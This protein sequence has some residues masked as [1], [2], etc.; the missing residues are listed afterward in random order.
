MS[1]LG[2]RL[3]QAREGQGLSLAQASV[4]TRILQQS[5]IAL[6]EGAYQR[7]PGDVVIRGFIR[8]YAQYLA[9]PADELIELYRRERGATDKIRIVPATNPPRSRSYV[10]PSFFGVFFVTVALIGLAYV[11]L[12]AIGRIGDGGIASVVTV[13][14]S[15]TVPPP[16]PLPSPTAGRATAIAAAPISPATTPAPGTPTAGPAGG[17]SFTATQTATASAPIIVELRIAAL[18]GDESS[19]VRVQSDGNTIY[20]GTMSSGQRQVFE[21]QRRILIRAGNPPAVLVTVNGLEQGPLGQVSGQPVNWPWP[22]N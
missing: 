3:R 17:V 9:L 16:S 20:E 4:D 11:T 22:P 21:A 14:P 5:L 10:L 15:A 2:A 1:E 7:L 18:R 6:E 8:N 13:E 19:W 12:N